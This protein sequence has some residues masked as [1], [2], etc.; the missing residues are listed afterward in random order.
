MKSWIKSKTLW[1]NVAAGVLGVFLGA[2]ETAPLSPE[3][4]AGI[5]AVGNIG[6]RFLTNT[7]IT[8]K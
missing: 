5:V 1:F 7:A 8:A 2:L 4:L 6:L 3:V